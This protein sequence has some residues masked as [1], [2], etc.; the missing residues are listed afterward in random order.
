[1]F[2]REKQTAQCFAERA[3]NAPEEYK[4]STKIYSF[5]APPVDAVINRRK[6]AK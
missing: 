6:P 5:L 4:S 2:P 3:I 1:L